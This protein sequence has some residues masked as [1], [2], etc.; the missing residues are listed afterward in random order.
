M[1]LV[2]E[3]LTGS[4]NPSSSNPDQTWSAT[5]DLA[6]VQNDIYDHVKVRASVGSVEEGHI[7]TVFA[8][9][10]IGAVVTGLAGSD[11]TIGPM[12]G[13]QFV[14]ANGGWYLLT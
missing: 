4:T 9:N 6:K 1:S 8:G 7:T 11:E 5:C 13:K 3:L 2:V 10:E 14:Y 12:A